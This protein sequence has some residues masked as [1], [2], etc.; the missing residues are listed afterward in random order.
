ML[1][2]IL[3]SPILKQSLNEVN[4]AARAVSHQVSRTPFVG[5]S[6]K[7]LLATKYFN[8]TGQQWLLAFSAFAL[9]Y[10]GLSLLHSKGFHHLRLWA[11]NKTSWVAVLA[12]CVGTIPV[13]FRL[14]W[15]LWAAALF[16]TLAP[17]VNLFLKQVPML[18]VLAQL[19]L[20]APGLVTY[21]LGKLLRRHGENPDTVSS[22]QEVQMLMS[23]LRFILLMVLWAAL[24]LMALD[25]LGVNI[26]TLVTGLGIGGIALA[27]A[28]Q[29]VLSDLLATFSI[30]FDKP[31]VLGD[32][33]VLDEFKGHVE[34]IGLKTTRLRGLG[35]EQIIIPNSTMLSSR[36]RNFQRMEERRVVLTLGV[37]YQT[38]PTVLEQIPAW[39]KS[40]V[41]TKAK[42]RFERAHFKG[43]GASSLDFETV[44]H[45]LSPEYDDFMD[46]QE[47]VNLEILKRFKAE[48]IDFA[49][50]TQSLF[51]QGTVS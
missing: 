13:L 38:E 49:Y 18:V 34:H 25:N 17:E 37:V 20:W 24:A 1:N 31:F 47:Q 29:N 35:G 46:I 16:I 10:L 44:Y 23:P 21:A 8:S 5:D 4:Q 3:P 22:T 2:F 14:I 43:F 39:I 33:I 15:G 6:L 26:T 19:G 30:V 11:H 50:P 27:L 42:T 41:E 32:F 7:I 12:Q 28:V 36:L 48:A 9:V 51:L 40:I 45:I